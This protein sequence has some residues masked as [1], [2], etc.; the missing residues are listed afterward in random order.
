[1]PSTSHPASPT[2]NTAAV[3]E[4]LMAAFG[5]D[6]LTTFC[7]DFFRR[8]SRPVRGRHVQAR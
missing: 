5:D 6:E 1:M 8:V 7:Y 2:Y 4:L 3:R